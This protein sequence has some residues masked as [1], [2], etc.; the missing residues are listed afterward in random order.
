MRSFARGHGIG[1]PHTR[2]GGRRNWC[3][4]SWLGLGLG[5]FFAPPA[6][7]VA[8]SWPASI[9]PGA[10]IRVTAPPHGLTQEILYVRSTSDDSITLEAPQL[11]VIDRTYVIRRE[12]IV[13]LERSVQGPGHGAR[14][15][16]LG[17]ITG[18]I[19]GNWSCRDDFLGSGPCILLLTP[20]GGLLG[21]LIG[22]SVR[23]QDWVPISLVEGMDV[24]VVP[25]QQMR[26]GAFVI[27]FR[28]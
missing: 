21:L 2:T 17:A 19:I 23:S 24:L 11:S 7:L 4:L 5:L 25:Q 16:F 1:L 20:V 15:L 18:A 13:S 27:A 26:S 8:Q 6:A 3:H 12:E 10:R 9:R 22:A 14:G 28:R